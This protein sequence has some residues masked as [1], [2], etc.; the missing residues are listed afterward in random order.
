MAKGSISKLPKLG[1]I[2]LPVHLM[3][4]EDKEN[5]KKHFHSGFA[6][7]WAADG[8]SDVSDDDGNSIG[9]IGGKMG[10]HVEMSRYYPHNGQTHS[11]K[12]S[13]YKQWASVII[14]VRDIWDQ[15]EALLDSPGV[16]VQ[17]DGLEEIHAKYQAMRKKEK[18]KEENAKV[19]LEEIEKMQREAEEEEKNKKLTEVDEALLTK[20]VSEPETSDFSD[21]HGVYTIKD[22][23]VLEDSNWDLTENLNGR[24]IEFYEYK[25]LEGIIPNRDSEGKIPIGIGHGVLLMDKHKCELYTD[26]VRPESDREVTLEITSWI[27]I[28][29]GA[30][31]YYGDL[32][33]TV[34]N[35]HPKGKPTT[36]TSCYDIELFDSG[37]IQITR[38]LESWEFKKYPGTYKGW[39]IG[40]RYS[41]FYKPE[42]AI[43]RGKEVF[44]DLFGKGWKLKIDKRY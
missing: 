22:T 4:Y 35:V 38:I 6:Y 1:E 7:W 37:K 26:I 24:D 15:I 14:D 5:P 36:W 33:F 39:R 13:Q 3:V 25:E 30:I 18:E 11:G 27:G 28:S 12:E 41:G 16:K 21:V 17:L 34:A 43:K 2:K 8:T 31:H 20:K 40:D 9:M 32:K 23:E 10:G 44:K 29:P 19:K 42:D